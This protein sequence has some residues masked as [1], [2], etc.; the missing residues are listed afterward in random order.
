VTI[1]GVL[2]NRVTG[3]SLKEGRIGFQFEGVP[4][5]L[6]GVTLTKLD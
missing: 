5:E 6:R 1:N 4:F 3:C 2:Q